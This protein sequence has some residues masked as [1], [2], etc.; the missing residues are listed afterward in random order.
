MRRLLTIIVLLLALILGIGLFAAFTRKNSA[1]SA[2]ET[3]AAASPLPAETPEPSAE[4]SPDPS[5]FTDTESLLVVANKKHRL[6]EGYV[7]RIL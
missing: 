4:P 1:A 5:A 2:E 3:P 6:P 7:P